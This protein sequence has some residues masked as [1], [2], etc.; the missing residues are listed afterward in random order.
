M[1]NE[2]YVL[3]VLFMIV[4]MV[5]IMLLGILEWVL[6][7]V[8]LRFVANLTYKEKNNDRHVF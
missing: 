5:G 7:N 4:G 3:F 6:D 2:V 1:I 8:I